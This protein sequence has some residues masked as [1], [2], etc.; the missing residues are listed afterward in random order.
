MRWWDNNDD[1]D[2]ERRT[3]PQVLRK[4]GSSRK[5]STPIT[6][7]WRGV[8]WRDDFSRNNSKYSVAMLWQS[9]LDREKIWNRYHIWMTSPWRGERT[10][11]TSRRLR[12]TPFFSFFGERRRKKE[13]LFLDFS[14]IIM[15]FLHTFLTL[16]RPVYFQIEREWEREREKEKKDRLPS[17]VVGKKINDFLCCVWRYFV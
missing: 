1:D 10:R 17:T 6:V 12:L 16:A 11:N 8:V 2:G 14:R 13:Q 3:P 4:F 9:T 5:N 7:N 15:I